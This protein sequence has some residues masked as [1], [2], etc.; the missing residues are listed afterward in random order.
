MEIL[1]QDTDDWKSVAFYVPGRNRQQCRERWKGRLSLTHSLGKEGRGSE[2]RRPW[3][4]EEDDRLRE[5][6]GKDWSWVEVAD[7]VGN[8]SDKQVSDDSELEG[9]TLFSIDTILTSVFLFLFCSLCTG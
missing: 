9:K 7:Y 4:K 3:T 5:C 8:R 1:G 2:I 6:A